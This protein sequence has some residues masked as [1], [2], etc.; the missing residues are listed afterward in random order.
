[1]SAWSAVVRGQLIDEAVISSWTR[2][3]DIAMKF[4]LYGTGI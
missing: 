4:A 1:L 2:S 3:I